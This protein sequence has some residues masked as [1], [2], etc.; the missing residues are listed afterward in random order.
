MFFEFDLKYA[1][2]FLCCLLLFDMEK[3]ILMIFSSTKMEIPYFPI[4]DLILMFLF[5]LGMLV[6]YVSF[7]KF[8][9][10]ICVV[11]DFEE[12]KRDNI[13]CFLYSS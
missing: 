3:Y 10:G 2:G 1:S 13:L 12:K 7:V 6:L 5:V 4:L 9:F 8:G 11:G